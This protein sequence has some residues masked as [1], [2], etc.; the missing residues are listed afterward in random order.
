MKGFLPEAAAEGQWNV[1]VL[2]G[3]QV[4][5]RADFVVV[6]GAIRIDHG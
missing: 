4:V 2:V 3:T 5:S 1:E 6:R